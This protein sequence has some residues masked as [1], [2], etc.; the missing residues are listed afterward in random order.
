VLP[1][2]TLWLEA[3]S[4]TLAELDRTYHLSGIDDSGTAT[5]SAAVTSSKKR[6]KVTAAA[7]AAAAAAAESR[8]SSK[9]P[10]KRTRD[11]ATI[12][13]VVPALKRRRLLRPDNWKRIITVPF[14]PFGFE[15]S[16]TDET[17]DERR[18]RAQ[19]TLH[20]PTGLSDGDER[21]GSSGADSSDHAD[22]DEE[23]EDDEDDDEEENEE[24]EE[25]E[26]DE[27][28]DIADS[29]EELYFEPVSDSEDFD[30]SG[31]VNPALIGRQTA[32]PFEAPIVIDCRQIDSGSPRDENE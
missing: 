21:H 3:L 22:V 9:H 28:I 7:A 10:T 25:D 17:D 1:T 6:Q 19:F 31:F 2:I 18:S 4:D 24:D 23:D 5:T 15:D 8:S 27:E 13:P 26:E 16:E 12:E 11:A 29:D 30:A 20:V 14:Q 32:V